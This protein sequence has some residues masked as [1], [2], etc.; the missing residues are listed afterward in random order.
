MPQANT[1]QHVKGSIIVMVRE[2]YVKL[3]QSVEV[4]QDATRKAKHGADYAPIANV[5]CSSAILNYFEYWTNH[6]VGANQDA[7]VYI[8][9]KDLQNALLNIWGYNAIV[10]ALHDLVQLGYLVRRNNPVHK[11]DRTWQYLLNIDK[12]NVDLNPFKMGDKIESDTKDT[13]LRFLRMMPYNEYLKTDH[14]QGVR[15]K[16]LKRAG[17]RCMLCNANGLLHVHHRTYENR[18]KEEDQD[19]IALCANCHAKHHDKI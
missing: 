4:P 6:K 8:T 3:L 12:L 10:N 14:W 16:A 13:A 7:W 18:G 19:V 17:H 11:Y 15:D 1:I 9:A 5:E 2:D